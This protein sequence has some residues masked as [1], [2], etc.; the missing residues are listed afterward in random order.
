[1][2][3][4]TLA[5]LEFQIGILER[6]RMMQRGSSANAWTTLTK[7][8]QP[9]NNASLV[10]YKTHVPPTPILRNNHIPITPIWFQALI[11]LGP[12]CFLLET[13]SLTLFLGI[14]HVVP[15]IPSVGVDLLVETEHDWDIVGS[16]GDNEL[17]EM[18]YC[19]GFD[20]V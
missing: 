15:V 20:Q 14:G 18:G 13:L 8:S 3:D 2:V 12:K 17:L 7:D 11:N 9:S 5:K 1:V 4:A 6:T 19:I 10:R 16:G